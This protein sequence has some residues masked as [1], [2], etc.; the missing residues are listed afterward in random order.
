MSSAATSFASSSR[1][2]A[3]ARGLETTGSVLGST[4][5][6]SSTG[7]ARADFTHV[8]IGGGVVGLAT[9]RALQSHAADS[10]ST[11]LL[12]RHAQVGTE[13]SSRNSEVIHAGLYYGAGTLK[14]ELCIRGKEMLYD[15]CSRHGVA[16]RR[17]GKWIVGQT[18][19]QR[20]AMQKVYDHCEQ[21][22]GVPVRWV[23]EAEAQRLEPDVR[24]RSGVLESPT[25]GIV[26]S[27]GLMVTLQ[28]LFEDAGGVT[29]VGSRV[30]DIEALGGG[31]GSSSSDNLPGSGGY[32]IT[33]E[34]VSSGETSTIEAETVI[35][36]AGLGA[37]E[38]HNMITSKAYPGREPMRLYYAKGNYFSY[39]ASHPKA[40]R[41]IYP[42]PTPGLGGLG[43]HL[44]LDIGG[45][46]KFG[47]DVEWV[48][49]PDDLTVNTSRFP[50]MLAAIREY[51]PAVDEA[52][53]APDYAGI[54]PKLQYKSAV[55]SG[56][57][58]LDFHIDK[59]D[60][61]AGWVN[62]LGIESPGLTSSLAIGDHV[63]RMFY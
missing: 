21:V 28:G 6:F 15:F 4:R 40:S 5:L 61:F 2:V 43:T 16:H 12:E 7:P 35:N 60:G 39:G 50:E 47:P 51:M 3:R 1:R 23:G 24:A 63:R 53:L 45:R 38:V 20:E 34:D 54:R 14:T 31:G 44:T 56:K 25:T 18:P 59:E 57:G 10:S 52:S 48:D 17:V 42:A 58:F 32:R 37:A 36:C 46:I 55:G 22:T 49:H 26:D 30:V 41:L 33:V 13:T 19:E 8:V 27:H 29:A 62:L 9:A 11:L